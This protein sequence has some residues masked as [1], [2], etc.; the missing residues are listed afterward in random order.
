VNAGEFVV[1]ILAADQQHLSDHFAQPERPIF[2]D[3]SATESP[4]GQPVLKNCLAY[5]HCHTDAI[6]DGGDHLIIVGKV[7][8]YAIGN[9][10]RPLLYYGGGYHFLR[11]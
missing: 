9:T 5:L 10:G 1:N 4:S 3:L 6:H 7:R 11:D 2:D 8:E